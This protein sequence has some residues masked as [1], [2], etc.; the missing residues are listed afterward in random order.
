MCF[1]QTSKSLSSTCDN[2]IAFQCRIFA[3]SNFL[4]ACHITSLVDLQIKIRSYPAGDAF[5]SW[6]WSHM[7]VGIYLALIT[8]EWDVEELQLNALSWSN[9]T[10]ARQTLSGMQLSKRLTCVSEYDCFV[11]KLSSRIGVRGNKRSRHFAGQTGL[12]AYFISSWFYYRIPQ[13]W[14]WKNEKNVIPNNKTYKHAKKKTYLLYQKI[15]K[16]W[17]KLSRSHSG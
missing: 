16:S 6:A 9:S 15:I 11:N 3:T 12:L 2:V 8:C 14:I 10:D 5:F 7:L 17:M 1:H 13:F 4:N